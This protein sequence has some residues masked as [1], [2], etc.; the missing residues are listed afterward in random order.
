M[1]LVKARVRLSGVK[2]GYSS[3]ALTDTGARMTLI[4]RSLAECIGVQYTGGIIDFVSISGHVVKALEAIVPE[5]EVEGEKVKYEAV[6]VAEIPEKVKEV[7]KES[8]VDEKIII[9]ILT[10]ERANMVPDTTTGTLKKVESFI[11]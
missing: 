6:A 7:L 4:D 9:G 10:I 11:L 1:V 5:L 8:A 3:T 2:E